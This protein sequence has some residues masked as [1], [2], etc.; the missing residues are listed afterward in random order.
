MTKKDKFYFFIFT[1]FP[2]LF[3]SPMYFHGKIMLWLDMLYYFMPMK[4][5]CSESLKNG[6]LPLWNPYIYCGNPLL[7]NMQSAVFYPLSIFYHILPFDVALCISTY[8]TFFIMSIFFYFFIRLNNISEEGSFF[9]SLIFSYNYYMLIKAVELADINVLMWLPAVLYFTKKYILQKKIY[10]L[11]FLIFSLA[12]SFLGGHLQVFSNVYLLFLLLLFYDTV[13]SKNNQILFFIKINIFITLFFLFLV[14][15]QLIPTLKFILHS[16]RNIL[17]LGFDE[18]G[19]TYMRIEQILMFFF[20]FLSSLFPAEINFFNWVNLI[21]IGIPS[22]II[23]FIG[24]YTIN[25]RKFRNFWLIILTFTLFICVMGNM[26]FYEYIFKIFKPLQYIRYVS[27]I[28]III[29]FVICF[30]VGIGFDNIFIIEKEKLKKIR[31]VFF[32]ILYF[33]LIIFIFLTIYKIPVLKIYKRI[34][35]PLMNFEKIYDIVILYNMFLKNF[36]IYLCGFLI[37]LLIMHFVIKNKFP[38][39]ILKNILVIL[40]FLLL[41][42]FFAIK[43]NLY[44]KYNQIKT[45]N[46]LIAQIKKTGDISNKRILSPWV[47][48]PFKKSIFIVDEKDFINHQIEKLFPNIPMIYKIKNVDGFDSLFLGN[49]HKLKLLM[50]YTMEPWDNYLF[51]LFSA[52]YIISKKELK[53]KNITLESKGI[54]FLYKNKNFLDMAFFIPSYANI[55]YI[56]EKNKDYKKDLEKPFALSKNIIFYSKDK[57]EI[58]KLINPYNNKNKSN[59]IINLIQKNINEYEII[60]ENENPGFLVLTDN[61]YPGWMAYINGQKTKLYNAYLTFKSVFLNKGKNKINFIFKDN[62]LTIGYMISIVFFILMLFNCFFY[63]NRNL[64]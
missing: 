42:E 27:K 6:I 4:E 55:L 10:D 59:R 31:D 11:F 24:C 17:G 62:A 50:S 33:L 57:K 9:S 21:N 36:V 14:S 13:L 35:D 40:T 39:I 15:V 32:I 48:D 51:G 1:I 58:Q 12:L 43:D 29:L 38:D 22:V 46:K 16:K 34:F 7:A 52:E 53:G 47:I 60:I 41:F 18:S 64:K 30:F 45:E 23:F 2:F 28:N 20:P 8:L 56:D 54:S 5:I 25:D 63:L 26:F 44:I 3:F 61:Y 37:T 49:F 19:S